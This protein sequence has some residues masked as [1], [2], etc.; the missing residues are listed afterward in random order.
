VNA[1]ENNQLIS[2]LTEEHSIGEAFD[3]H[4]SHVAVDSWVACR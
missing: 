3:K 2:R 1:P 4:P